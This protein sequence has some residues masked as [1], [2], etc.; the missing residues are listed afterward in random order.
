MDNVKYIKEKN[1]HH[2]ILLHGAI[3]V[4]FLQSVKFYSARLSF[5]FNGLYSNRKDLPS[6]ADIMCHP[7]VGIT[8]PARCKSYIN[9]KSTTPLLASSLVLLKKN[10][11]ISFIFVSP[12]QFFLPTGLLYIQMAQNP[13]KP[14]TVAPMPEIQGQAPEMTKLR[15]HS[16]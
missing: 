11:F 13:T 12:L 6:P 5:A 7:W 3:Q 14:D 10:P 1:T 8:W 9:K 15:G 2:T 16:S 4:R